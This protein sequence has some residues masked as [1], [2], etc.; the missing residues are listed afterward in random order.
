MERAVLKAIALI[1][2]KDRLEL[3]KLVELSAPVN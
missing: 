1:D 3:K 2:E